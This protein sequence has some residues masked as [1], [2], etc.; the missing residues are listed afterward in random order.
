M[1]RHGAGRRAAHDRA[2]SLTRTTQPTSM[3]CRRVHRRS[4]HGRRIKMSFPGLP[5]A[6]AIGTGSS[7]TGAP[8]RAPVQHPRM[9]IPRPAPAQPPPA[10]EV[11]PPAPSRRVHPN[12]IPRPAPEQAPPAP[13]ASRQPGSP[14]DD[15]ENAPTLVSP[16]QPADPDYEPQ[17]SLVRRSGRDTAENL[18]A[19]NGEITEPPCWSEPN[20]GEYCARALHHPERAQNRRPTHLSLRLSNPWVPVNLL[21]GLR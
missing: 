5:G 3:F 2:V 9:S 17:P 10:P 13:T 4:H 14:E 11:V 20:C 6:S 16:R 19:V 1:R 12:V 18:R 21:R 7:A 15:F 8:S